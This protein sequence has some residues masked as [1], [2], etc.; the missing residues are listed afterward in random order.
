MD[1][2]FHMHTFTDKGITGEDFLELNRE[3]LAILF[4]KDFMIGKWLFKYIANFSTT[5]PDSSNIQQPSLGGSSTSSSLDNT[6][7]VSPASTPVFM[8]KTASESPVTQPGTS[9]TTPTSSRKRVGGPSLPSFS[10]LKF[11]AVLKRALAEDS[12]Y[13]P[14]TRAK[15]II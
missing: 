6:V 12:F 4:L 8:Q 7:E 10:L 2:A 13:D 15:L 11:D 3:D 5:L 14:N 1:H 9:W